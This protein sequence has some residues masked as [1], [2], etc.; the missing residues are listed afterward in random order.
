MKKNRL[1]IVIGIIALFLLLYFSFISA[2]KNQNSQLSENAILTLDSD[3]NQVKINEELLVTLTLD[4]SVYEVGAADFIIKYDPNFFSVSDITTGNYF[5]YY[6]VNTIGKDSIKLSGVASY[7]GDV[8]ILPKGRDTVGIFTFKALKKGTSTIS[9]D[10]NKTI[11]ATDG[12]NILNKKNLS[13]LEVT[14]SDQ[15]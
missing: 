14:I 15:N 3:K 7:D 10:K 8:L 12:Q 9:L 5:S 2:S 6:P 4:S 11:V 1:F 13:G